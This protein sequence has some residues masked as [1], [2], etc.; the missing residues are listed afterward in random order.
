MSKPG[1][2]LIMTLLNEENGLPGLL[3]SIDSQTL[4]PDEIVICE[5][6][7]T[8]GTMPILR[9]WQASHL[10]RMTIIEMERL[11]IAEGRNQA[12]KV[13]TAPIICV[14]DGGC[15]MQEDWL[16]EITAPLTTGGSVGIVYGET[17]ALGKSRVG[18]QFSFLYAMKTDDAKAAVSV[19]SSRS[20]AFRKSVWEA[21]GGYP[22][23]M[24]LA[25]E[26]TYFFNQVEKVAESCYIPA[27]RVYWSHGEESLVKIFQRHRRNSEGDS[28]ANLHSGRYLALIGAYA[29]AAATL[30]LSFFRMGLIPPALLLIIV[31]CFRHTPL[32]MKRGANLLDA[33]AVLPAI[34]LIRDL[35]MVNGYLAG[36]RKRARKRYSAS[37]VE[38]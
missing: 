11:N 29:A 35:G 10:G 1:I 22:E 38:T 4:Q 25:G 33:V 5:T 2:A 32:A 34:T 15:V 12:I 3:Q 6:G 31:L 37:S 20:V 17:V 30:L 7:S 18:Q 26:D 23:W 16:Q 19:H 14:T 24:T 36:L 9:R 27:A 28:E 8:D 13:S 21:V